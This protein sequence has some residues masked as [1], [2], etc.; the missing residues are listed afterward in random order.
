MIVIDFQVAHKLLTFK[1]LVPALRAAFTADITVPQRHSHTVQ[2]GGAEGISLLMPAWDQ[3]QYMG[4]KTVN[5]FPANRTKNLPG[6]HSTYLLFDGTTGK[7][8]ASIDGNVITSR[9]TAA[10]SALAAS[11]LAR[12]D[13][14]CLLVL[15]SGQVAS[16][17]PEAYAAVR[18]ITEVLV[19][20]INAA[21]AQ[22]L[23]A[24]L[25]QRSFNAKWVE[26]LYTG[27]Q[28]ADIISCA[29]L[30][31]KPLIQGDWLKSGQHLDLIGSFT[32]QMMESD[33]QCF[34]GTQVFMDTTEAAIKAGDLLEAFKAG[35]L[36]QDQIKATLFDLCA[37]KHP[38]RVAA[39]EITVFKS[40]GN[41]LEDLAAAILIYQ[42]HQNN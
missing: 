10:A 13:A 31:E 18:D 25:Q 38:G 19:W 1:E 36:T 20:N 11:Y 14:T 16:F 34:A 32:P 6:L 17:L 3:D 27:V 5:I 41:A 39:S 4:I 24:D 30:S 26:D 12:K 35:V 23:V 22:R 2:C 7:P 21:S 33:P 37:G 42:K 40:V 29:T 9:R 15:G 28:Q 8:L